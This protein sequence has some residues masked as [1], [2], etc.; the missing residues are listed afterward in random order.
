MKNIIKFSA[1][2]VVLIAAVSCQK[3]MAPVIP[4]ETEVNG[5]C[6][7]GSLKVFTYDP[8]EGT[9]LYIGDVNPDKETCT[10]FLPSYTQNEKTIPVIA[11]KNVNLTKSGDKITYRQGKFEQTV[12]GT[13]YRFP[14]GLSGESVIGE[15]GSISMSMDY[16]IKPGAMPFALAH[17]FTGKCDSPLQG[18]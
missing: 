14:K 12:D 4:D 17:H 2:A 8:I 13:L 16:D 6:Y 9:Q 3:V 15:D 7:I 10:V 11:V 18:N 5:D 1:A